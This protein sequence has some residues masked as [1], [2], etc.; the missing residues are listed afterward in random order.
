MMLRLK[1]LDKE[2]Y[3]NYVK[4]HKDESHFL[5]SESLTEFIKVT[6]KLNPYYLG[7]VSENDEIVSATSVFQEPL[8]MNYCCLYIPAGFIMDYKN[9]YLLKTMTNSIINF[10]NNKKAISI[11]IAPYINDNL[12][13]EDVITI[14]R[15]LREQGFKQANDSLK[16]MLPSEIARL[17]LSQDMEDIENNFSETIK[18]Y[19]AKAIKLETEVAIGS[20]KDLP[21]LYKDHIVDQNTIETLYEILNGNVN[22]KATIIIGKINL[23]KTIKSIEKNIKKT[24]DQISILPI[25]S[26]S[27]NSKSKLTLLTNQK[28]ELTKELEKFRS[29]KQQYGT[30]LTLCTHFLIEHNDKALL[31]YEDNKDILEETNIKYYTYYK[32]IK[33]CKEHNIKYLEQVLPSSLPKY[34][35]AKSI[36]NIGTWT[37][38]TKPIMNFIIT[39]IISK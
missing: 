38:I 32:D 29:Y 39:K 2:V 18:E 22:T 28:E 8:A 19:L 20:K 35:Q 7:L 23:T 30:E 34:F 24:N 9:K 13:E 36:K 21:N 5:H 14:K 37:Y 15:N 33:Y 3:D 31:L 10:A 12:K 6:K 4:S 17:D 16:I 26:L 11:K 27:K 25:D 1:N